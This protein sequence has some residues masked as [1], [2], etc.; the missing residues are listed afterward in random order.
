MI[1]HFRVLG[2]KASA[3]EEEIKK[4]YKRWSN[5]YHPDKLL[6]LSED[7]KSRMLQCSYSG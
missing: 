2:V 3:T 4:A 6:G 7:R 5:K 1:N